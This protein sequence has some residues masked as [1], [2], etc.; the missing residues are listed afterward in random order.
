VTDV[1]DVT[2]ETHETYRRPVEYEGTRVTERSQFI[3]ASVCPQVSGL[4][5]VAIMS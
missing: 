1:T 3:A 5:R 4:Q 2:I